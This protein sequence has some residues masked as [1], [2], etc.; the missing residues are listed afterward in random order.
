PS[1]SN[2]RRPFVA[3]SLLE[4]VTELRSL[5]PVGDGGTLRIVGVGVCRVYPPTVPAH[6]GV[7]QDLLV[8]GLADHLPDLLPDQ[9]RVLEY[10]LD[11]FVQESLFVRLRTADESILDSEHVERLPQ[12]CASVL[13]VRRVTTEWVGNLRN[14]VG[15]I[16]LQPLGIT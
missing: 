6:R 13:P 10:L 3:A 2:L 12:E 5:A 8:L 7:W 9:L 15:E 14:R 16:F 1:V 11:L 4:A